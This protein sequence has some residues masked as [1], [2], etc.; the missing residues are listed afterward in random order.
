MTISDDDCPSYAPCVSRFL[1]RPNTW[2]CEE[3][4]FRVRFCP[5]FLK[6]H[7][8]IIS[9]RPRQKPKVSGAWDC[10]GVTRHVSISPCRLADNTVRTVG[11][12]RVQRPQPRRPLLRDSNAQRK[13]G[14]QPRS[15]TIHLAFKNNFAPSTLWPLEESFFESRLDLLQ[16]RSIVPQ[17]PV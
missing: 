6:I 2:I 11:G 10:E 16:A 1:F 4:C 7:I 12:A 17:R 3:T 5:V 15:L 9:L 8:A 14:P 13:A